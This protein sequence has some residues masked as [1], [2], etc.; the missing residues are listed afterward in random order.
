MNYDDVIRLDTAEKRLLVTE[1]LVQA[2]HEESFMLWKEWNEKFEWVQISQGFGHTVGNVVLQK[3]NGA[4]EEMPVAI[5]M[6]WW[7]LEGR[8][9]CFYEDT[10]QVVDHRMVEAWIRPQV[11]KHTNAT[12]FHHCI[13]DLELTKQRTTKRART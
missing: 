6:M 1:Y 8:L 11:K 7:L 4:T 3:P 10:S 5:S 13:H 2:T 12:N 9:V